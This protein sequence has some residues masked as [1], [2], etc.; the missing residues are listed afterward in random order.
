MP[1]IGPS[2]CIDR[3]TD[4]PPVLTRLAE[5][6]RESACA[7]HQYGVTMDQHPQPGD[8]IVRYTHS[9]NGVE[10]YVYAVKDGDELPVIEAQPQIEAVEAA[11]AVAK[12]RK[13][14]LE[15]PNGSVLPVPDAASAPRPPS[16]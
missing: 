13:V 5:A 6:D 4:Q 8:V 2:I 12:G 16:S 1:C 11:R 15:G 9:E 3:M 7:V 14:W 10:L